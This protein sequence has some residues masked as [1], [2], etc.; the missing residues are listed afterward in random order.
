[1][2]RNGLRLASDFGGQ[3]SVELSIVSLPFNSV[4]SSVTGRGYRGLTGACSARRLH[5]EMHSLGREAGLKHQRTSFNCQLS[6]WP[7]L[8]L[9]SIEHVTEFRFSVALRPRRP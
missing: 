4:T 1:M 2:L 7:P 9:I 3:V 6:T 5:V 8:V